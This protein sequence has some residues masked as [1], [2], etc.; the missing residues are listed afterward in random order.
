MG[1]WVLS[2]EVIHAHTYILPRTR[3]LGATS[4]FPLDLTPVLLPPQPLA[5]THAPYHTPLRRSS[6][7][8]A[9]AWRPAAAQSPWC[10][11]AFSPGQAVQYSLPCSEHHKM[12]GC[13]ASQLPPPELDLMVVVLRPSCVAKANS[14]IGM[15][16]RLHTADAQHSCLTSH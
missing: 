8:A 16:S 5:P 13:Q 14:R 15:T 6:P 1:D 12:P 2:R 4:A 9:P 10:T 11:A 7:L 3:P